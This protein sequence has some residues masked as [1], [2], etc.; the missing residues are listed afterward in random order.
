MYDRMKDAFD[1]V[2]AEEA[3]KEK[4]RKYLYEK[5]KGYS[6]KKVSRHGFRYGLSAAACALLILIGGNWLYF[7]PTAEISIDINPSIELSVNR[8]D[9]VISVSGYNE[10][11]NILAE[12]LDVKFADYTDAIEEVMENEKIADL[13]SDDAVMTIAVVGDGEKQSQRILSGVKQCTGNR[14]NT[15]CYCAQKD[16]V[17]NAHE[18][19]LS[20]G[21][22]SA[23]LQLQE[24][25]PDIT[26]EEVS[27]MTMREIR[28]M[29]A[30][31]S[32]EAGSYDENGG[33]EMQ[34]SGQQGSGHGHGHRYGKTE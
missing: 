34:G 2:H 33:G 5:T 13:L 31:L 19:G 11:G 15:Y 6:G 10:D 22:Y 7:T 14:E 3:L 9:K 24:L 8:F 16:E 17:E 25:N 20:Y 18:M 1:R 4:T 23:Y 32:G 29:I 27:G 30:A 21:K 12:Q 26:P 28:D